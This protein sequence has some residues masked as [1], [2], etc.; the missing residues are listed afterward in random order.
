[1]PRNEIRGW[2]EPWAPRDLA[3]GDLGPEE[4][5]ELGEEDIGYQYQQNRGHHRGLGGLPHPKGAVFRGVAV[6]AGHGSHNHPKNR[7]LADAG[8]HVPQRQILEGQGVVIGGG[9]GLLS[10]ADDH[11]PTVIPATSGPNSRKK[12]KAPLVRVKLPAP[13]QVKT[14]SPCMARTRPTAKEAT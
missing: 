2:G 4:E 13:N 10:H 11:P 9:H 1:M 8:E 7:G 12:V 6:K 5:R 14:L 3:A